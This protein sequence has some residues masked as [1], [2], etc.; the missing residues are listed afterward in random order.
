MR[1]AAL[2]ARRALHTIRVGGVPEHFN[3]PW[4]TAIA[5]GRF[6]D[7][8]IAVEWVEYKG[9]T[10]AMAAALRAQEIDVALILTEGIVADQHRGSTAQLIGTWVASPLLWGV[11][12]GA[13]SG[14][15]SVEKLFSERTTEGVTYAVSRMGS[16]S[17][18]MAMVDAQRF[19]QDAAKKVRFNIV[20]NL[21]GAREALRDGTAD[22]F[23][24]EKFM[25]K[26]YVDNGEFRLVD[27]CP[28]P[29]PC[30]VLAATSEIVASAP[31]HLQAMMRVVAAEA[32]MLRADPKGAQTIADMWDLKLPDVEAWIAK[33]RW[34]GSD[35]V[36]QA[37]LRDVMQTLVDAEVLQKESLRA[38]ADLV[39]TFTA[40]VS[41]KV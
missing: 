32:D 2:H 13:A 38:P 10:G 26:P 16:G 17:Q 36:S 23:M 4:H 39:S 24:W 7:A 5:A 37:M 22:L 3:T 11:H 8:G 31:E 25:T 29:W 12:T 19:G 30:F 41:G 34:S 27:E 1:S 28:T 6:V 15:T 35:V 20:G 21:D 18:L 9:G 40:D 33:T 14:V